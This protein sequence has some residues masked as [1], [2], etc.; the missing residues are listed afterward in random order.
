MKFVFSGGDKILSIVS[1]ALNIFVVLSTYLFKPE[2]FGYSIVFAIC[3]TA[4]VILFLVFK[5]RNQSKKINLQSDQIQNLQE[6]QDLI[7]KELEQKKERIAL[8]EKLMNVPFFKKWNLLCTFMWRNAKSLLSNPV[9]LF[10][11]H[12]SRRLSGAGQLKD[13]H[14]TYSFLGECLEPMSSFRFCIAGLGNI[15]LKRIGFKAKDLTNNR[16]L[17]FGILKNSEDSDMKYAEIFFRKE[18]QQGD[19]FRIELTWNWPKTAFS[20]SDY[21]SLAN[22]Y[23]DST[24]RVVLDLYPT[25]DMKLST[26]ETYKF[27]LSDKEPILINHLYKNDEGYYHTIIDNPEKDADYI[28]YYEQ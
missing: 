16:D 25:E 20:K 13:N 4:I 2:W 21:F 26:F 10:E 1:S 11:I 15:P 5:I 22:I 24:K 12:V 17:D 14:V 19:I 8:L 18:L 23:S 6:Q 27:G 3:L 7:K 9:C 28:T